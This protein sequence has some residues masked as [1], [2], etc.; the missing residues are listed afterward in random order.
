M[1]R[2]SIS[3][4]PMDE[5]A[6]FRLYMTNDSEQP[7]A[8]GGA[9][10][11]FTLYLDDASNPKGA[12]LTIDGMPL[13]RSGITVIAVP[14]KVTEKTLE[15]WAGEDYDY[16]NLKIGLISQG[17]VQ[18]VQ[19]VAFSVHF[20]RTAGN[21]EIAMP[22]DK[23]I[24]NTDAPF[25][26]KHGWYIPVIISGFNKNQKNFDHIEFQYK[27]STRGDDYWTNLCAFYA[28]S[29]L[30]KAATGTHEM[31]PENG[32]IVTKFYGDGTVMEKAYDLRARLYCRSGNSFITSD[33]K[34]LSGIKDTRRPQLFGTPEPK[35]GIIGAGDNI[36][37]NF[38]EAIEHNYLQQATNFEVVG[39]TNETALCEEPSLLFSGNGYAETDARRN[40]SNKNITIDL[41]VR[42][43]ET[44]S[45]MPI[46]SH[47]T[48]GHR[49]QL[50]ITSKW[51]LRA[52][53]D[54]VTFESH[55]A[56]DKG[57]LQH[58]ALILDNEHRQALLY[59]DSIIGTMNNV[60]YN[61]YGTLI[62][63]ATNEVDANR[64]KH[65]SGRMLEARLWNRTM[66]SSLLDTYG[67]RLLTGYEMGLA[68]YY[69]MNEGESNY[70]TD[71]AQGANAELKGV[72]WELP[73]GMSLQLDYNEQ[74]PVKGIQLNGE[75]MARSDEQD[76][77]LMLWFKTTDR[78]KGA[79]ISNGS[80]RRTDD[81]ARNRFYIGFEGGQLK[82]RTNGHEI[83]LG[84]DWADDKW[85]HF[86]LTVDRSHQV[87][88]IYLDRTLR[89]SFSTDTLGGMAA[90]DF[91]LGN[92]VWHDEGASVQTLHSQNALSGHIDDI[93][94]FSQALPPS[95]LKRYST[96]SPNGKE[97]GLLVYLPFS[98][99]ERMKDNNL[100]MMP[101][102]LSQKVHLNME[103]MPTQQHDTLF[104]DSLQY[105]IDHI[106]KTNGAPVQASQELRN[107]NFSFVGRDNQLLV[108]IDELNQRINKRNIYVTVTD[109][110]DQNGNYMASPATV[111]FFVDRNSLRWER[112]S[113]H[114]DI[115]SFRSEYDHEFNVRINNNSGASHTYQVQNLPRWLTVDKQTDII[116]PKGEHTLNFQVSKDLNV[117]YYD[118][119]IYLT[120]EDGLAEPLAISIR[121][122]GEAPGWDVWEDMKHHSMNVVGLVKI[123]DAIVTDNN[124]F[125]AAFDEQGRCMGKAYVN[126]NPNTA[127]SML[128]IT[129]FDSTSVERSIY[130]KLWHH[131]TGQVMMLQTDSVVKFKPGLVIGSV[132]K[133]LVM[134]GGSLYYQQINVSPG[135]NWISFN[136]DNSE[137]QNSINMLNKFDWENG[138][139]VTD[140]TEDFTL[141]YNKEL[142]SWLSNKGNSK[143][144]I[145]ITPER[146]YRIFVHYYNT[147][148]IS[149]YPLKDEGQRTIGVKHGWN[150][151]GYTPMVN[152]PV[153][154]ALADYTGVAR[155][156]DVVK[157][158]EKFA[159]FTETS[160]G[161]GYWS[162]SLEYMKPGEGYMLYRNDSEPAAFRYPF[163][164]PGSAFF[165]GTVDRTPAYTSYAHNM[166]VVASVTGV[167]LQPGDRLV[168][169]SNGERRGETVATDS[170]FFL[171]IAGEKKAPLAFAI[172]REGEIIAAT[173]EM[174]VY[175]NNALSGTP[176]EP[177]AI[178]FVSRDVKHHDWYSVEGYKL[179]G[180]PQ[181]KGIYI[182]NGKKQ[183]VK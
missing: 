107:L 6:R 84:K 99:Q 34:V 155:N 85:H 131:L 76:Y 66:T 72:T 5:P 12:R 138:D 48:D 92:M 68:A 89:S 136:V 90:K 158:R 132:D 144:Q 41:M 50:W 62:F 128:F 178:G 19:E 181:R 118:E 114:E 35:D 97:K 182:Y 167:E 37:F 10:Q 106:D 16:E 18:C 133:P 159:V 152:L 101:Y 39:E 146:S 122:E 169:L 150:N 59:N 177:T 109:I 129:V 26:K 108:N 103:G 49:L 8:I 151:I 176:T 38:S 116:G 78:G 179:G 168:A 149:G 7:E 119:I 115:Y 102:A 113:W 170:L 71:M 82:Y 180:K 61:G 142:G 73:R 161:N 143:Q 105:V 13:S 43:N 175:E 1:D 125:V 36:V 94:L 64:R 135:W 162:G 67:K 126:Y 28:D 2:Q 130:F 141:V 147:V 24:M 96:K 75:L 11:F 110:P 27:E 120:D 52:V 153:S 98:R 166:S 156:R 33:S 111:E 154:T 42:P 9:L 81:N 174:M 134:T 88:N 137:F 87:A 31:I 172:E 171:S 65:Y 25:D 112:K 100:E 95:L 70:A 60:A 183:V 77:T 145:P 163:Y 80:G 40:F 46:F 123:G 21:V 57:K 121:K 58:V 165:E 53:I 30:Y 56:I 51:L 3:G 54:S 160:K 83:L 86:A 4:V 22:G 32:N 23:W 124:D 45:D 117:G 20:L 69:P 127:Q 140:D 44:D 173:A 63:G 15:V 157:S 55:T 148:G 93:C 164:E 47:G 29:T 74:K 14:G 91:Y 104:V 79:L 17:D 139:I